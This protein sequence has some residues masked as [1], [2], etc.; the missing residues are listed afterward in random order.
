[1]RA[2]SFINNDFFAVRY[3]RVCPVCSK[4]LIIFNVLAKATFTVTAPNIP[5]APHTEGRKSERKKREGNKCE[6]VTERG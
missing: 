3:K 6:R 5:S 4:Y 2:L 1:L